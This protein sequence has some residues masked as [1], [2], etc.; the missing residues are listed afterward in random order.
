MALE[1]GFVDTDSVR[2]HYLAAGDPSAKAVV[3]VHGVSHCGGVWA[4]LMESLAAKGFYT[5]A[6]DLRGHGHSDKPES[7]YNWHNFRDDVAGVLDCLELEDVLMIGHSRG[8][9]VSILTTLYRQ[10]RVRGIA[11]YEPTVP[12]NPRPR[13]DR[14]AHPPANSQ[15]RNR[16]ANRRTAFPSREYL[17]DRYRRAATF[18]N[19][20]DDYLWAYIEHG[21]IEV[22]GG[23]ELLCPAWVEAKMYEFFGD[24]EIWREATAPKIPA[25]AVFG[26]R[27]GRVGP[28]RDPLTPV[29]NL[30]PLATMRVIEGG[31]HFGPMEY[32]DE[33]ESLVLEFE[34]TL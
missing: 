1:S 13:D 9:G 32:P 15:L 26:G 2:I 24:D 10:E 14:P 4:P 25:L 22:E 20:R 31:T 11:V 18:S 29:T 7:G 16:G 34:K 3:L 5:I 27:G 28:G 21:S 12:F 19:W 17:F 8:G 33:F 30:L 23:I 6:P